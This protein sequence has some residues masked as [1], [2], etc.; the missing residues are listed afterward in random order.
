MSLF[1]W[2]SFLLLVVLS[3]VLACNMNRSFGPFKRELTGVNNYLV[4][5][6]SLAAGKQLPTSQNHADSRWW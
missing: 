6:L 4:P 1:V 2:G 3:V 5:D